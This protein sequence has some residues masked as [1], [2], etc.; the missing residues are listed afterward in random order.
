MCRI[1]AGCISAVVAIHA[2]ASDI[3]VIEVRRQPADRAMT[4]IAVIATGNM[5]RVFAGRSHA[6]VTGTA[7]AEYLRM[8]NDQNGNEYR[9]AVA[10]LT[11]VRCLHVRRVLADRL[12]TIVTITAIGRNRAV[13]ERGRQPARGG[14]AVIAGVTALN[15]RWLFADCD[16]AVMTRAATADDLRVI[17][18]HHGCEN[19][20]RMTI[21]ANGG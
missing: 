14:M 12:C 1:L 17:D 5:R 7:T 2:V 10:V 11:D 3:H 13:I 6:I 4:V 8:V 21:L 18:G 20:R 16:H 19:I 15:M 9:R